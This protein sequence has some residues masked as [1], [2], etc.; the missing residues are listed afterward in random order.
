VVVVK[1]TTP[2]SE[3]KEEEEKFIFLNTGVH[4]CLNAGV[5]VG[6]LVCTVVNVLH[7]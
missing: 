4:S 6:L 7:V 3:E 2:S 5:L 1:K